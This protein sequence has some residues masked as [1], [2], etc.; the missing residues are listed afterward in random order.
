MND[1]GFKE[2]ITQRLR[3]NLIDRVRKSNKLDEQDRDQFPLTSRLSQNIG[4]AVNLTIAGV[5]VIL[6]AALNPLARSSNNYPIP[7]IDQIK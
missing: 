2:Y 4:D 6:I 7:R 1:T 5:D 3:Q